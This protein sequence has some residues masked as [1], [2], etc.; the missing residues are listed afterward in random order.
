MKNLGKAKN[1]VGVLL[2]IS[3]LVVVI[4]EWKYQGLIWLITSAGGGWGDN[5]SVQMGDI[6]A[7][8]ELIAIVQCINLSIAWYVLRLLD[9][10]LIP[11][12]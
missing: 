8:I 7:V 1:I 12:Y 10:H 5:R 6:T 9:K 11:M 2:V 4:F 3:I